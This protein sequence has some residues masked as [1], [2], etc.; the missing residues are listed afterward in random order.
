MYRGNGPQETGYEL[1]KECLQV[2]TLAA[3]DWASDHVI[4]FIYC[5]PYAC[6]RYVKLVALEFNVQIDKQFLLSMYDLIQPWLRPL[7]PSLR[8]RADICKVHHPLTIKVTNPS[9]V[10]YVLLEIWN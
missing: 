5:H 10:N 9:F 8:I 4:A 2:S 3:A 6:Y 1:R 7:S